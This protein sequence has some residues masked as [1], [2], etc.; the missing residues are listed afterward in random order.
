MLRT[1]PIAWVPVMS[2]PAW[3]SSA[4]VWP[5]GHWGG[6]S[7]NPLSCTAATAAQGHVGGRLLPCPR[8]THQRQTDGHQPEG[9]PGPSALKER[10][11]HDPEGGGETCSPRQTESDLKKPSIFKTHRALQ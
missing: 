8:L 6:R 10:Q 7:A 9:D 3:G 11:G 4:L 1:V 5:R 2:K